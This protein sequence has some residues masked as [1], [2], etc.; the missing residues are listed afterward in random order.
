MPFKQGFQII[1]QPTAEFSA[2][3]GGKNMSVDKITSK[4]KK[5]S[6]QGI[7]KQRIFE[8]S[9]KTGMTLP[10]RFADSA[11]WTARECMCFPR[12]PRQWAEL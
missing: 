9:T 7:A 5:A 2:R 12:I 4:L 8:L 6:D 1:N 11:R 3:C 10:R